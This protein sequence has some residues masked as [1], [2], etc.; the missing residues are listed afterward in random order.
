MQGAGRSTGPV[1]VEGAVRWTHGP[2]R[3]WGRAVRSTGRQ[4]RRVTAQE[5]RAM[6]PAAE[7]TAGQAP[8]FFASGWDPANAA[9]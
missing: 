3:L 1:R 6:P 8:T 9:T 4:E 2:V 7:N 5:A